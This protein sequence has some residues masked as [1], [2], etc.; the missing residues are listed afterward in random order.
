MRKTIYAVL[1]VFLFSCAAIAQTTRVEG[2]VL[3][4]DGKPLEG[5]EVLFQ[6]SKESGSKYKLKT[7]KK[8]QFLSIGI[9]PAPYT[10]IL[11]KNGTPLYSEDVRV[12]FGEDKNVF[13]IDLSKVA[14]RRPQPASENEEGQAEQSTAQPA[15]A[16]A[17]PQ[18]QSGVID[19]CAPDT[20]LTDEQIKKLSDEQKKVYEQCKKMNAQNAQ[21][22]NINVELKQAVTA[23]Q[24]GNPEQA[25]QILQ[26]LT[27]RNPNYPLLWAL[28]GNYESKAAKKVTDSAQRIQQLEQAAGDLQKAIQIAE[29]GTDPKPKTQIPNWRLNYGTVLESARKHDEAIKVFEQ[30]A[31]ESAAD[32]KAVALANYNAGVAA[33][34]AGKTDAAVQYFEKA[35]TADPTLAD[36]Y[37]QKGI[38]LMGKATTDKTGKFIAP[39]GTEEAFEKYLDLAPTGPNAEAAK[40]MLDSM[41]AKV[42]TKYKKSK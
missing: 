32:P 18:K 3:D 6:G 14:P 21:I 41:G 8:G 37:Y 7:N 11:S 42:A 13:D 26:G 36:A 29:T 33:T 15:P 12:V 30:V 23:D 16:P 39:P 19:L 9:Q 4:R 10:L 1:A 28:Q 22:K 24:G 27:Q 40:S 2:T 20:V 38:A 34:N 17:E 35:L 5:A 25:V 31:Q